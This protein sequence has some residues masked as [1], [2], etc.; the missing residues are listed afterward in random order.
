[1][2]WLHLIVILGPFLFST[3]VHGQ[4]TP[5]TSLGSNQSTVLPTTI[6]GIS[7]VQIDGGLNAGKNLLH[8]FQKFNVTSGSG[9]YF[10]NPSGVNSILVRISGLNPSQIDGKL[11]VLGNADLFFLNPKGILFGSNA[12]LDLNGSFI[13]ST[14][15]N[16]I[17]SDGS[18]FGNSHLPKIPPS[19]AEIIGLQ[20]DQTSGD[21]TVIG[22]GHNLSV[23]NSEGI[24]ILTRNNSLNGLRTE[25]SNTIGLVA[26]SLKL[27]GAT[28]ASQSGN[29]ELA[30]ASDGIVRL[31]RNQNRWLF[32]NSNI[33]DFG[34]IS[35]LNSAL[36]DST[37]VG[38]NSVNISGSNIYI[39][40][41]SL[42]LIEN[43]IPLFDST[44]SFDH[45]LQIK[46]SDSIIINEIGNVNNPIRSGLFSASFGVNKGPDILISTSNL[47]INNGG[48]IAS[49]SFGQGPGGNIEISAINDVS[50][51]SNSASD[52]TSNSLIGTSTLFSGN[53][54]NIRINSNNLTISNGGELTSSTFNTGKAGNIDII[55][56]GNISLFGIALSPLPARILS[57]RTSTLISTSLSAGQGGNLSIEGRSLSVR[58][59]GVIGASTLSSGN[60]GNIFVSVKDSITIDG[61]APELNFPSTIINS[62]FSMGNS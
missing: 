54:G 45:K 62:S 2:L 53:G 42:I 43:S 61:V 9:A 58:D 28:I 29:I 26:R 57:S 50:I 21:I 35:L 6:N 18:K 32:D 60:S 30:G 8:R 15:S 52:P 40:N 49:V 3:A 27:D 4:I 44:G 41:G 1:M 10:V 17:F 33:Q 34:N 47:D 22:N 31:Y 5:D 13:G 23:Q 38:D 24:A 48:G 39:D 11:G 37:G 12:S 14:A 55:A 59:G 56:Q 36:I 25:G 20:M 7:S 16:I 19:N 51:D 46:A